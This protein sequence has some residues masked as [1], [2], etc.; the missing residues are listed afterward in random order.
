MYAVQ[1]TNSIPNIMRKMPQRVNYLPVRVL[2]VNIYG[3]KVQAKSKICRHIG[4]D[5][6]SIVNEP[7]E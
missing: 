5:L 6:Y 1:D 7:D 4:T 3:Q 2:N